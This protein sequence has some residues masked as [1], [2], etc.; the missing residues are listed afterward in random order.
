M[1]SNLVYIW[2]MEVR[3]VKCDMISHVTNKYET[4][5]KYSDHKWTS[6][7]VPDLPPFQLSPPTRK[8]K[9]LLNCAG[10]LLQ[11]C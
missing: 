4:K 8:G 11:I 10:T 1:R 9:Y 3:E 5:P 6:V 2:I 7:N